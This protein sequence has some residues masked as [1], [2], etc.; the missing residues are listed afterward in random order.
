MNKLFIIPHTHYDAEVFLTREEYL[1][2]GYKVII[3]ALNVLKS[4]PDY[5]YSLDQSAFVQPF[6]K[7]YP[8]LR[9]TFI[10]MV[11]NGRLE[12]IGG[13]HVM[14]DLNVASGESIIRQFVFGKGYYKKELGI[15]VKTGWMIDTFGHC[16]QMPQIMIKCGFKYYMFSRVAN[17]KHSEFYWQGIDGTKILT[18]WMAFHYG[19]FSDSPSWYQGFCEFAEQRYKLLKK[20]A[21]TK[22]IAAPEGG[23]FTYP[24]R[25]DTQFARQWNAN[26]DRLFDLIVGTPGDF[27]AEVMKEKDSLDIVTDDFNPVF[28][29]C[30]SARISVK[31]H[32]RRLECLL[33]DTEEWNGFSHRLGGEDMGRQLRDAW[34]P[35]L[36]NQVHDIIGGVQ[37][38]NVYKNVQ[39]RYFQA[40][41][42]VK[43]S[44]EAS[45][46]D[47]IMQIDTRGEGIPLVIFNSLC[48][49]RTD[50]ATAEIAYDTDDVFKVAVVDS[51]GNAIPLQTDIMEHYPNGAI[52]QAHLLFMAKCPPSGY[53][54][55]RV[56][57]NVESH[58]EN[59]YRTGK[60]YGME[61]LDKGILENEYI[62][63]TVDLWKGCIT[64][65]ILKETGAELIDADMSYGNMLVS[66]EDN[67][68]FWEIGTPLRGGA[69]RPIG[70][71]QPLDLKK[72]NT[73]L[74]IDK[75]GTCNIREGNVC[76]EFTFSQKVDS[77][78]YVT[79]V[80]L[81]AG[82]GRVEIQTNLINRVKNVRYRIAFPTAIHNGKITQEIP[83]GSLQR[84][85]GEY[86]A[87]NWADYSEPGRGLG[88]LNCGLPGNA[89]VDNKLML[90]IM[91]CTSFV[92]YGE[93]G[94]FSM[95]NS[96]EGGHEINIPH[97]FDYALVPHKGDWREAGLH[98][99]GAE[100]NHPLVVRKAPA[101]YGDLPSS[102]SFLNIDNWQVMVSAIMVYGND[103]IIRVYEATGQP[104]TQVKATLCWMPI[105]VAETN[106]LGEPMTEFEP[107]T[108]DDLSIIFNLKPYE[109]RTFK[110]M[111]P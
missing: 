51:K 44:L 70:Q 27:F 42:L 103:L 12:I 75:G 87:I 18:H 17:L 28:Q 16:L 38:D 23:D 98:R 105:A 43:L 56:L 7:A 34:E 66:D 46:D 72:T 32:N 108:V 101:Q 24:V 73:E 65:L 3:D 110:I 111:L 93:A 95:S 41:N 94:G 80:R 58:W 53:E 63:L 60:L 106:M 9:D 77:Y 1:E 20:Y 97:S 36:F 99:H 15:D 26:P 96:S 2:V 81:Y 4:D 49:E 62:R 100:L 50:K 88:M 55:Y 29:G 8:E 47:L 91:K 76:T 109:V 21:A 6:L 78:D 35:V 10:E 64:S 5:K 11:R 25:H 54:V 67:G 84:P 74:S 89:V 19:L 48:W 40:D 37:M 79:H 61:E 13:M 102:H 92:S 57:K 59:P 85:E 39:K 71:I 14:S 90:S 68:D 45:L 83:F 86:P 107:V 31:Q 69:N 82:L 30:Y 22:S 33:Y 52:R 104:A